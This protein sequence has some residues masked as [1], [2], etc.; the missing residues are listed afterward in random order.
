[1]GSE[2]KAINDLRIIDPDKIHHVLNPGEMGAA[3]EW[4]VHDPNTKKVSEHIVKKSESYVKQFLQLLYCVMGAVPA[5]NYVTVKNTS[6][7]DIQVAAHCKLY[8]TSFMSDVNGGAGITTYGIV[9]GT[10]AVAP[11][12]NDYALGTLIAHGTGAG[13]LQ[14]S[15]TTYGAPAADTTTSQCTIT[16]N[17]ANASGGAITVNEIGLYCQ[18]RSRADNTNST[19]YFMLIRDATGGISVPNGQTLTVNYRPQAVV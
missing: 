8:Q 9:V 2:V 6:N 14:Y 16:R 19:T 17:F 1:M 11:T 12:I 7:A 10:G 3:I 15:A 5:S 18:C 13:Q 4:M